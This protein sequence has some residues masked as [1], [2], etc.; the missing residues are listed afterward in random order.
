[1][2]LTPQEIAKLKVLAADPDWHEY[3]YKNQKCRIVRA[4][5]AAEV[6]AWQKTIDALEVKDAH[7]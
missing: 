6:I 1:M 7:S 4:L 5:T 2:S 3:N